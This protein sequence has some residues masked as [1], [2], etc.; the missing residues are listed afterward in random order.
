MS[1]E[2]ITDHASLALDRL[3]NR[4][5]LATQFRNLIELI[6]D[7]HQVIEDT[8]VDLLELRSLSSATGKQ[9]DNAGQILN[10]DREIGETDSAYRSRLFSATAQLEKSGEVESILDVFEFLYAPEAIIYEEIYPAAFVLT[11][12][13]LDD[14]QSSATD[15]YNHAAIQSIKAGGIDFYIAISPATDY[16]YLSDVSEVDI[17]GDGPI[18]ANHGLGDESLNEG[19]GLS[20]VLYI[21]FLNF[22]LITESGG[23]LLTESGD[24]ITG[25]TYG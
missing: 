6:G 5:A 19:G 23:Q 1:I 16:L 21:G 11:A 15:Q 12:H 2:K 10:V 9:L 22:N 25:V 3:P 14:D 4:F 24:T 17:N 20:R 7:R 13:L 8:L 18:D